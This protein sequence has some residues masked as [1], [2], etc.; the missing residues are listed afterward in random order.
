MINE[1]HIVPI[2]T[3]IGKIFDNKVTFQVPKYQR[4][5]AWGD[6]QIEDF[7][8]DIQ[9]CYE[10]KNDNREREHF[11]GG[12]VSVGEQIE[13]SY[14]MNYE[15]IDGQ[16]RIVSFIMLMAAVVSYCKKLEKKCEIE[17]DLIN[18]EITINRIADYSKQFIK[19]EDEIHRQR[20]EVWRIQ[21]SS[22][23]DQFFKNIINDCP[24]QISR[25]SHKNIE[26]AMK[27]IKNW[28]DSILEIYK[29]IPS[30]LDGIENI[31]N[32][33]MNDC[34]VIHI[35]ASDRREAYR[36]FQVLNDRG[37][38]LTEGDLLKAT[39][40]EMLEN[41]PD[42]ERS[43]LQ[44]WD[45][46]LKDKPENTRKFIKW[47]YESYIGVSPNSST[48]LDQF[49]DS[50]YP[51]HK[52][53]L[54]EIN[55]EDAKAIL[56][57]IQI[58]E[59]DIYKMRKLMKGEDIHPNLSNSKLLEKERVRILII[60]LGHTRCIPLLVAASKLDSKK[61]YQIIHIIERFFFRYKV[62]CN[63][64]INFLDKI[65]LEQSKIIRNSPNKYNL[66]SFIEELNKLKFN[67]AGDTI[68]KA[69]LEEMMRYKE[70][71][72]NKELKYFLMTLEYY[73]KWYLGGHQGK[74]KCS[75]ILFDFSNTTIEH[76]YPRKSRKIDPTIEPIKHKIGNL[77]LLPP[78]ENEKCENK[79]FEE[80]IR[81]YNDSS[82]LSNKKIS[83]NKLWT[84]DTIKNRESLMIEIALIIFTP[85]TIR[86]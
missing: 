7:L 31:Y 14:R 72:S 67:K 34:S 37:M 20:L 47:Y 59:E 26:N 74:P 30:K 9:K 2:Y 85:T 4:N 49:L 13:G 28:V 41:Y 21:L 18:K 35:I 8:K 71:S 81:L 19:Y 79:S 84:A 42:Y 23:D 33:I 32:V 63:I 27:T 75:D 51:Q 58:F 38:N 44:I 77:T 25:E 45:N 54:E 5:Y 55:E 82:I 57:E 29:D 36:L 15:L 86:Y 64:H 46:I 60:E 52:K 43:A 11:F 83:E 40:L 39:T 50:F 56:S 80:K 65:Y 62:I 22:P 6:T 68:F 10:K 53:D 16:Q 78:N 69:G 17:N 70:N 3:T 1:K 12:I 61:Y 73:L 66:K 24:S 48:L 76:V